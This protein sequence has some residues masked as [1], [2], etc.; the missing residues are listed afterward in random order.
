MAGT[1]KAI[2]VGLLAAFQYIELKAASISICDCG[3]G[4]AHGN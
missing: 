2:D 4:F 3:T 1:A